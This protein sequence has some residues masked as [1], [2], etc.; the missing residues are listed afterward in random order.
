MEPVILWQTKWS[1]DLFIPTYLFFGGVTAGLF[2]VAAL[3]D[4]AGLAVARLKPL[5]RVAALAA[6]PALAVAGFF[7]TVHLGKPERGLGFPLFF[8]NYDSWM[9]RGGWIVGAGSPLVVAYAALW[10]FGVWPALRRLI[11]LLGIPLLAFLGMYTGL[12][13]SGAGYVPMWPRS[14]LPALFLGSGVTGAVAAA[15]L[16]Y[17]VV[18]W[19]RRELTGDPA[20]VRRVVGVA[21]IALIAFELYELRAF[22]RY[23]ESGAPDKT[24]SE[25]PPP[26]GR[27][28]APM[29]S[30]LAYRYL[31]GGPEYPWKLLQTGDAAGPID[32][33]R[34][35]RSLAPWFW[36]GVVG[37]GLIAPLALTV[38]EFAADAL[39]TRAAGAIAA[40][41]FGL[42]LAGGFLLRVVIVRGGDLKAP[43][44]FPPSL[45]QVPG[46]GG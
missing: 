44:P 10:Y 26:T 30:R 31:T 5:S 39:S 27:F 41:K 36:I 18:A 34:A 7:L 4:L 12:L 46:L 40:L 16:T 37:A 35:V 13:L 8:T 14:V 2:I 24:V 22:V 11:A 20:L 19:V 43:L 15:G 23:L 42:V 38:V 17:L 1:Q 45:W 29:G 28:A 25:S 3:A 33:E 6:V 21:L 32:A 9:T